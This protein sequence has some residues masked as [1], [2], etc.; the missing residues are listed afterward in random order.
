M[1]NEIIKI[2]KETG[3]IFVAKEIIGTI[4][5]LELEKKRIDKEYKQYKTALKEAMEEYGVEKI[6]SDELLV[7]YIDGHERISVDVDKLEK[8]SEFV[9]FTYDIL[10]N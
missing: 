10:K 6:D 3:E 8:I 1:M 5:N 7:S 2:D 4:R 9:T